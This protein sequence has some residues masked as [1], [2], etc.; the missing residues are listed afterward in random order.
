MLV[1]FHLFLL[2]LLFAL[3]F[4]ILVLFFLG[5]FLLFILVLVFFF[6]R[7]Q[8]RDSFVVTHHHKWN[9]NQVVS[10]ESLG[11][12]ECRGDL[13]NIPIHQSWLVQEQESD[14]VVGGRR[15]LQSTEEVILHAGHVSDAFSPDT[16]LSVLSP[17]ILAA[18]IMTS[19]FAVPLREN[20][21]VESFSMGLFVFIIADRLKTGTR[22]P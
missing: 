14:Q 10:I 19:A 8:S 12:A 11:A 3:L 15:C 21:T 1:I 9:T 5:P 17:D 20:R 16:L 6:Y 13:I 7:L 18:N 2:F 22:Y 4:F